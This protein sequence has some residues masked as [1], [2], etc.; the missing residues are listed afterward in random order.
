M[1]VNRSKAS[2]FEAELEEVVAHRNAG[3]L[4]D[5]ETACRRLLRTRP[6]HAK[7]NLML[8]LLLL[9]QRKVADAEAPLRRVIAVAPNDPDGHYHLGMCLHDQGKYGDAEVALRRALELSPQTHEI[10]RSLGGTLFNQGRFADSIPLFRRYVE[11]EYGSQSAG[12]RGPFPPHKSWHDKEQRDYLNSSAAEAGTV[13]RFNLEEGARIPGRAVNPDS[14]G[15]QIAA[16]WQNSS[17]QLVVI[18]NVLTDEALNRLRHY[19]WRSTIWHQVYANGYIGAMPED[20]FAFPLLVQIA[21]EL[22]TTYPAILH[23]LALTRCWAFKYDSQLTGINIHADFAAVNINFWITPDDANL[24]PESGGLVVWDKPA[25][26][27]WTFEE[28]NNEEKR[29]REFLAQTAAKSVTIPYR[30]N[31]AV[32]FDSD[33]FHKT[34]KISFKRGYLNRRI[35]IT[36]LYGLREAAPRHSS[37]AIFAGKSVD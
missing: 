24:D 32:I 2:K 13:A 8:G 19:C 33:L 31:R 3:R 20:G 1:A 35:N 27:E 25:P 9:E 11:L 36:M 7:A 10:L 21:D 6:S 17:P 4:A 12:L 26:L 18:D 5:A 29:I 23:D 28:Y 30:S 14:S 34:D 15:G 22:R 16:K 37:P